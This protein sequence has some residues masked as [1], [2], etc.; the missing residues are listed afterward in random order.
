MAAVSCRAAVDALRRG[1]AVEINV[2][3]RPAIYS[4]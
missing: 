1:E 2:P 3:D 4:N